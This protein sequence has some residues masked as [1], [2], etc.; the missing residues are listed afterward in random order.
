MPLELSE[1][2]RLLQGL[3]NAITRVVSWMHFHDVDGVDRGGGHNLLQNAVLLSP[4][5]IEQTQLRIPL[6]GGTLLDGTDECLRHST[7]TTILWFNVW[8]L[9]Q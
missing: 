8:S 6:G 2:G 1:T 7:S 5:D 4:I 3:N 9:L